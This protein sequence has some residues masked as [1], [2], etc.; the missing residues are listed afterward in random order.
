VLAATEKEPAKV[1]ASV[2]NRARRPPPL[3]FKDDSPLAP[4]DRAPRSA[5]RRERNV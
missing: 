1:K 4:T 2:D 5:R 3:L